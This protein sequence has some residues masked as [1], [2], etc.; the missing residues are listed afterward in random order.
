MFRGTGGWGGGGE[1]CEEGDLP[2]IERTRWMVFLREGVPFV[3]EGVG[4]GLRKKSVRMSPVGWGSEMFPKEDPE[5]RLLMSFSRRRLPQNQAQ[6][7]VRVMPMASPGKKPASTAATEILLPCAATGVAA[8]EEDVEA[9]FE[10]EVVPEGAERAE[11]P[12]AT[13]WSASFTQFPFALQVK[14]NGQ[15]CDPHVGRATVRAVVF[16]VSS[17]CA[18]TF[19]NCIS[20]GIDLMMLQSC[21]VGQHKS[22]VFAASG[23]QDWPVGQQKFD[24]RPEREQ[25]D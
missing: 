13:V 18:V 14:P 2:K 7:T 6:I 24:G 20:Q 25:G 22:V 4:G 23:M 19:C 11:A 8:V 9:G 5:R 17:G 10:E 12:G 21:P 3:V 1:P 15:H 16:R